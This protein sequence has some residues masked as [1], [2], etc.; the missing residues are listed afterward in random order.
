MK[1]LICYLLI[2]FLSNNSLSYSIEN[3]RNLKNEIS[4][5]IRCLICQGQSIYDSQ[6]DFAISMKIVIEKKI[7]EG[8]TEDEIYD[9]LKNQYGQWILYDP[10]LN[11]KTFILWILP[12]LLFLLGGAIIVKK[13]I[14][15]KI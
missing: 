4:K 14:I 10:E 11:K 12:I 5:N 3:E 2:F 1:K 6:S 15:K 13:I 9:Y 7:I 8:L